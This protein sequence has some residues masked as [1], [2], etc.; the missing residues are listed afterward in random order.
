MTRTPRRN[1]RRRTLLRLAAPGGQRLEVHNVSANGLFVAS[2]DGT[3]DLKPGQVVHL[4]LPGVQEPVPLVV[5]QVHRRAS[6]IGVQFDGAERSV[7]QAVKAHVTYQAEQERLVRMESRLHGG[8]AGNLKPMNEELAARVVLRPLLGVA[9]ALDLYPEG[10]QSPLIGTLERID[11]ARARLTV[12][13]DG[14]SDALAPYSAVFLGFRNGNTTCLADTVVDSVDGPRLTV[15]L[16]ERFFR[17]ERRTY[18]REFVRGVRL[19]GRAGA[20]DVDA[21]VIEIDPNGLSA[22]LTAADALRCWEVRRLEGARLVG[23]DR[24]ETE[25]EPLRVGWKGR[26][27]ADGRVRVGF[28]RLHARA[29]VKQRHISFT[30]ERPSVLARAWHGVRFALG[31]VLGQI[32]VGQNRV[33]PA[34]WHIPDP[35]GRPIAALVNATFSLDAVPDGPIA[36]V[37]LPPP[38][39]RRKEVTCPVALTLVETFR[40]AG[41]HALVVRYDGINHVGESW[42]DPSSSAPD[43]HMLRWTLGQ[44]VR[45]LATVHAHV[46]AFLGSRPQPTAIVSFSMSAVAT[47]RYLA[48][49]V[50]GVDL[51]CAPMGAPD[52]RDIIR[53][54]SG[55]I[56]W[57]GMRKQGRTLGVN[58]IQGH[59]LD[60]DDGCDEMLASGLAELEDARADM[61]AITQPVTWICGHHDYWVNP[62][63]VEDLLGV[64]ATGAR[65]LIRVPTG[66]FVRQSGEAL[67]TFR[68]IASSVAS[69][70]LG[71][72]I[73]AQTPTPYQIMTATEAE[74][75]R[76]EQTPFDARAYWT[77][78]LAGTRGNPL[79]FDVLALTDEYE[80]L[81]AEQIELLALRAG[82]RLLDL[83]CGTGNAL[84]AAVRRWAPH[85]PGV[86]LDGIDLVAEAVDMARIK[87]RDACTEVGVV[88]PP[89]RFQVMDLSMP[90][91]VAVLPYGDGAFDVVLIS[92]VLPYLDD[93]V[94]LLGQA[95]RV[96]RPGGRLIASTLRPDSDMGGPLKRLVEKI[97]RGD[98]QV[99]E[100]WQADTLMAAVQDY[101]HSAATLL[102]HEAEGRFTFYDEAGF[103]D[104]VRS[105][106]FSVDRTIPTFGQPPMGLVTLGRRP[107]G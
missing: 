5:R 65:E 20:H 103:E 99:K 37:L 98:T 40:A 57:V 74:R 29:E 48:S 39:A 96:L 67:E 68:I 86:Q 63:R 44:T 45:D 25:L 60:C 58:L 77:G 53:N 9:R 47:R 50:T 79:G 18:E 52:A 55:G 30:L 56:D 21:E 19:L 42:R 2:Q 93:P 33:R 51:W 15:V 69:G 81:M 49:G 31:R 100:G 80:A 46:R 89:A 11:A 72:T 87:V 16:P 22:T 84:V 43:L 32:G 41:A 13:L 3:P 92:L 76:C 23:E 14:P 34:V 4:S 54:S 71:R 82:E 95:L 83:G 106:G 97:E 12:T 78:Y 107:V 36:V 104:L 61:A 7:R 102:E 73:S 8:R 101:I 27:D 105:A 91:D 6:G 24:R 17:P 28:Q 26:P 59:L 90:G 70:L 94:A 75:I 35:E 62:L 66:H 10:A 64:P 85:A 38:F 1:P 88:L